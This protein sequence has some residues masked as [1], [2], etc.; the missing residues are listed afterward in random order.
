MPDIGTVRRTLDFRVIVAGAVLLGRDSRINK[1]V[2][3]K[4]FSHERTH[5]QRHVLAHRRAGDG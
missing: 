3:W 2:R 4:G 5:N 1:Q